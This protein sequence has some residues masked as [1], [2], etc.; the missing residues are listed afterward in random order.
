LGGISCDLADVTASV[1]SY[2]LLNNEIKYLDLMEQPRYAFGTAVL[3]SYLYV[4]GGRKLGD[5][6]VILGLC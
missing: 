1:Y 6:V 3:G 2:N 5:D 4:I